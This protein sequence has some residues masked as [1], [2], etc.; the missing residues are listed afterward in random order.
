MARTKLSTELRNDA[1]AAWM[2]AAF[3]D[4]QV[5]R[6]RT[7]GEQP[8]RA[9]VVEIVGQIGDGSIPICTREAPGSLASF[10]FG[11]RVGLHRARCA[12][13]KNPERRIR[14]RGLQ[15]GERN[16]RS[17][18]NVLELSGTDDRVNFGNAF[19]DLGAIALNQTTCND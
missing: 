19:L 17:R 11:T 9:L 13:D 2:I 5:R 10:A 3:S 1:E 7:R 16:S 8:R 14:L 18:D 15:R 12:I 6:S 4:L